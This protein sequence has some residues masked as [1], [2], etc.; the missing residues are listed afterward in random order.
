LPVCPPQPFDRREGPR[1]R[2]TGW[3]P[4]RV[5]P[6][7]RV[8]EPV[9]TWNTGGLRS[10]IWDRPLS[11]GL[12]QPLLGLLPSVVGQVRELGALLLAAVAVGVG[13]F[14]PRPPVAAP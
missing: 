14:L 6:L 5:N 9:L 2:R 7:G 13:V 10:Q 8:S 12:R 11:A 4:P 3:I 1:G